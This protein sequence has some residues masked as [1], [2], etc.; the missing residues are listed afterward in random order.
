MKGQD[1]N[2]KTNDTKDVKENTKSVIDI[3]NDNNTHAHCDS[4]GKSHERVGGKM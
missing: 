2:A 1:N 3:C 4:M